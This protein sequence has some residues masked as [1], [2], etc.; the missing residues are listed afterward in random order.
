[1]LFLTVFLLSPVYAAGEPVPRVIC[2]AGYT[3]T[4]Y[5]DGLSSPDGLTFS[6]DGQLYVAEETAGQVSRIDSVGIV[7]PVLTGLASPEGIAFDAAGNLYV[8]E[9]V[10]NGRL[11]KMPPGATTI[12]LA[13]GLDA[14]ESVT[15]AS[16]NT[17]YLTESNIQF[18]S[19]FSFQ[20]G[21]TAVSGGNATS[22][23]TDALFW[24]YSGIAPG[25]GGLLYVTNEASGT[26]TH[27][28]IFT[29]VPA[30][31]SRTLFTK[32]WQLNKF[33]IRGNDI[34]PF[35]QIIIKN[36]RHLFHKLSGGFTACFIHLVDNIN[37]HP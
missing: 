4:V 35:W 16:D 31:G 18:S 5:A 29:I 10:Q 32:D 33:S 22:V 17:I 34:I 7:V 26:G 15:V 23:R 24:S 25:P 12:P 30:T 28:S 3:V 20:T 36:D 1:M 6:P 8:V 14:P 13:T 21:V 2:P 19:P 11:L 9:D 37:R 27:D